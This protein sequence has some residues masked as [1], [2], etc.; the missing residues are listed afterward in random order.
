MKLSKNFTLEELTHSSTADKYGI[1]NVPNEEE[2]ENLMLL[3]ETVLQPIRERYGKPIT[4]SS[5]FR[6]A[7]LNKLVKGSAT[8]QHVKGEA[9]DIHSQSDSVKD[10][11]K[12]FDLIKQMIDKDEIIVGQLIDEYNYNWVHVSLPRKNKQNN[13]ILH[14]N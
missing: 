12:L 5:G 4:V 9:A 3:C 6:N 11:K 10:N 2:R 1:K 8:S 13:M 14:I 7:K